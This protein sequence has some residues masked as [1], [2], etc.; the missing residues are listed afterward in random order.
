MHSA[1]AA[2]AVCEWSGTTL[3]KISPRMFFYVC[4]GKFFKNPYRFLFSKFHV[5]FCS[6]GFPFPSLSLFVASKKIAV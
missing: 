6:E 2:A 3:L 4:S 1:S 5:D